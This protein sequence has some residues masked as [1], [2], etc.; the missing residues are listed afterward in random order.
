M[1]SLYFAFK[2]IDREAWFCDLD[3]M[4]SWISASPTVFYFSVNPLD[5]SWGS[6]V[7]ELV[8]NYCNLVRR[9]IILEK[10]NYFRIIVL[11]LYYLH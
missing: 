8:T 9:N 7:Q 3:F 1:H 2:D 11:K 6:C 5:S 4:K 10:E